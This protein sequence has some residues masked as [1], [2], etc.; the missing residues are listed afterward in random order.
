ML[1]YLLVS[2]DLVYTGIV[3][4][5]RIKNC[6]KE[7]QPFDSLNLFCFGWN[8]SADLWFKLTGQNA[9]NLK[10]KTR[11]SQI[12]LSLGENLWRQNLLKIL[13]ELIWCNLFCKV[14]AQNF[15]PKMGHF[16]FS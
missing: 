5:F 10:F 1:L 13:A 2:K 8:Y 15:T 16:D 12:G 6:S 11:F 4:R 14:R 9:L 7:E 3:A